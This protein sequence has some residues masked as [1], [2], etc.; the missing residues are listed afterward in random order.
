[1][2]FHPSTSLVYLAARIGT[3]A[4]HAP[5]AKW[6]YN[7]DRANVGNDGLCEGP[8]NAQAK[9]LPAPQGAL[10]AWDPVAKKTVWSASYP[11]LEAGGALAT[12]GNL[13]FQGR[14]DGILAAY[15]ANDGRLVAI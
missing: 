6:K 4:L 1:M 15:R 13:V 9:K 10:L 11:V 14:S 12:A 2:A 8:L 3:Q 7:R 5:N